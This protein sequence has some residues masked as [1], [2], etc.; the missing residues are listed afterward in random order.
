M[1]PRRQPMPHRRACG[2]SPRGAGAD[3]RQVPPRL[4]TTDWSDRLALLRIG[5]QIRKLGGATCAS[6][7]ASA[8]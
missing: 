6:C 4:G 7:C 8:A 1:R 3:A 5:W 2:A